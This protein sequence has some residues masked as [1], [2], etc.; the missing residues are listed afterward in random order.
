V[1]SPAGP[2]AASPSAGSTW[3]RRLT[4]RAGRMPRSHH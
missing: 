1:Q 2:A 4:R 3:S